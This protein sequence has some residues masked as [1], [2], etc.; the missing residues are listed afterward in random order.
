MQSL[1]EKAPPSDLERYWPWLRARIS[2]LDSANNAILQEN[3]KHLAFAVADAAD[4]GERPFLSCAYNQVVVDQECSSFRSPWT[5]R[6]YSETVPNEELRR[7]E[8]TFN[9]VWDA[10]K[11][12][13]YGHESVGSVYLS[14]NDD[15]DSVAKKNGAFTGWFG[16]HK[17]HTH[18]NL[19]TCSLWKSASMVRVDVLND[20]EVT[21]TVDTSVCVVLS[22]AVPT[23]KE[24]T[25]A[26]VS[27]T[28]SKTTTKTCIVPREKVQ[29][30]HVE[31]IGT[32][33]EAN[34]IDLRS[35]LERVMMP[36]NPEILALLQKKQTKR[37]SVNPLMGMVMN[38]DLLKRRLAKAAA[39]ES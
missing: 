2:S 24:A 38:S 9:E 10:Y 4:S 18:T 20:T 13:Y 11:N 19:G 8:V 36:K 17:Q 34:E 7:L 31:H 25:A 28:L 14:A 32:L 29:V 30:S 22:P 35:N 37:P 39:S 21:Y 16:I 6:L 27:A 12:L 26:E 23:D 33:I 5:N 15:D 3:Y 1:L